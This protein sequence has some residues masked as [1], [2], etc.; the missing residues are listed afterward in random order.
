VR[1][2]DFG[3]VAMGAAIDVGYGDDVGARGEGLEDCCCCGGAG[4][5]CEGVARVFEG[6]DGFFEVIPTRP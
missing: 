2:G 4:R 5:E 6:S 3:E 1:G